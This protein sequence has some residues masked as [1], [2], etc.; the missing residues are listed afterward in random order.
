MEFGI[1][2]IEYPKMRQAVVSHLVFLKHMGRA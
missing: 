1:P 2:Y